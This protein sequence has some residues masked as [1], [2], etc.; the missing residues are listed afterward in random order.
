LLGAETP[1]EGR[2]AAVAD[3]FVALIRDRAYRRRLSRTDALEIMQ[4]GRGIEFDPDVLDAFLSVD[5]RLAA[6]GAGPEVGLPFALDET[7]RGPQGPRA[8]SPR[9]REVL[10]LAADGR[11]VGRSRKPSSSVTER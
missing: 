3:V 5:K 9:E 10:Q 8:I 4:R 6:Q 2:I 7:A 11:S 1:L